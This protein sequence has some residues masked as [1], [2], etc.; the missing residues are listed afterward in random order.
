MNNRQILYVEDMAEL[1]GTTVDAVR[2]HIQRDK[3]RQDKALPAHFRI[4]RRVAWRRGEV[5][6]FYGSKAAQAQHDQRPRRR[7]RPPK[8][9]TA[10]S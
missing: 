9:L 3:D 7:G 10:R 4:G 6:A 2:H 5:D 1:L 8:Q